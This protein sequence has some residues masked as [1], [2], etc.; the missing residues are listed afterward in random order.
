MYEQYYGLTARP[1]DLTPDPR[2]LVPTE[3]HR[4]AL[5]NLEYAIASRKGITLLIGEAGTGKTT[6]ICAAIEKQPARVHCVHLHNPALTR[7]EFV[8]ML[9]AQFS[10][11]DNARTSKTGLLLELEQLLKHRRDAGE[12]T[13]LIVDEA[14]SLPSELLDEI[15]LLTNIETTQDK[16]LSLII[17]GQP[18]L[19]VRVNGT[20]FRQLKQR[21]GL[22]CELRPL[23]V[24]ESVGYIA[25]RILVAGGVPA[26]VFTREAV[27]LVH[28]YARGI[29][30]TMNVLADNALVSGFAAQERPVK[31]QLV[32]DV[33]IDFDIGAP[34][35]PAKAARA[36]PARAIPARATRPLSASEQR[37]LDSAVAA[38]PATRSDTIASSAASKM[39]GFRKR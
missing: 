15:R 10:L 28:E 25:K 14:Q 29:P 26:Q 17:A 39:F 11:S 23:N 35:T 4:E 7:L 1:F 31:M 37:V 38:T 16:L 13:V 12:T 18:E 34:V 2:F 5:S 19:A 20:S 6:V 22:R 30:R 27:L 9:A 8:E 3:V 21:I 24:N 33:C 36:I 32:R